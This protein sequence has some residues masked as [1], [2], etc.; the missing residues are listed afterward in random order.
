MSVGSTAV[1][2]GLYQALAGS[3]PIYSKLATASS[4]FHEVAPE[5]AALPFLI[6]G[7]QS[8]VPTYTFGDTYFDSQLWMIKAVGR[9]ET[10]N[11]LEAV[12]LA[13]D[14]LLTNQ[15]IAIENGSLL[16]LRRQSDIDYLEEDDG[17]QYRHH[18]GLYRVIATD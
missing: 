18:G 6:F 3:A 5:G 13:V 15:T 1:A 2:V 11:D 10:S 8:G 16:D 12:Q 4:I 9:S 7:K 17:D 14:T